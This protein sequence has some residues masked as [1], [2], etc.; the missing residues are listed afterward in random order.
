MCL[1]AWTTYSQHFKSADLS[2][3]FCFH[4]L[5]PSLF[6]SSSRQYYEYVVLFLFTGIISSLMCSPFSHSGTFMHEKID[7]F[8]TVEKCANER[9]CTWDLRRI[10][11][12]RTQCVALFKFIRAEKIIVGVFGVVEKFHRKWIMWRFF[13]FNFD[14]KSMRLLIRNAKHDLFEIF[15]TNFFLL[16]WNRG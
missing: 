13:F 5:S 1:C 9:N 6:F 15:I 16:R 3:R 12:K 11:S 8:I 14:F 4:S 7:N 10:E 2:T